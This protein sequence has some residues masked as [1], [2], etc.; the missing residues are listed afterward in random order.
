MCIRQVGSDR[1]ATD[2]D[3]DVDVDLGVDI[4]I[5]VHTDLG[6]KAINCPLH[7]LCF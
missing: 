6:V 4:D 7:F 1:K 2:I 5:A 3:S